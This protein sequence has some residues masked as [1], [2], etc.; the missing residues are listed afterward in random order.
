MNG[1]LSQPMD[2]KYGSPARNAFATNVGLI[3]SY[4]PHGPNI[5][6]AEWT[7]QISYDPGLFLVSVGPSKAT[8]DNILSSKFF[9]V[10][11][12]A[13]DQSVLSSLAGG[14]SGKEFSKI[15]YLKKMG[16]IFT[17]AEHI[18]VELV[19][20]AALQ[21][22]CTLVEHH[23]TGDHISFVGKVLFVTA[24]PTKEPLVY[25]Q[26]KYWALGETLP[27]PSQEERDAMKQKLQ[28]FKKVN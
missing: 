13:R 3:T 20:G 18:P 24:D 23:V 15:D 1:V 2:L 16:F 27:K 9:G 7:L 5:M 25:H 19:A 14:S 11:I 10:S 6:A 4:G 28:E 17:K 12:A 22:E 21:A 8:H 26:G